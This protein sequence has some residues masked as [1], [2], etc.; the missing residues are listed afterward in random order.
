MG[1]LPEEVEKAVVL[2]E[3]RDL[4]C[5]FHMR[6]A[7]EVPRRRMALR[8]LDRELVQADLAGVV[9]GGARAHPSS[10]LVYCR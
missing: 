9:D 8:S 3:P 4:S 2:A 10:R 6:K 5:R 1:D 7:R